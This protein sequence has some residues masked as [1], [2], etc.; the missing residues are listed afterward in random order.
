MPAGKKIEDERDAQ[1]CLTAAMRSGMTIRD[2]ARAQGID[3]RSLHAWAMNLGRRGTGAR[4]AGRAKA[5]R[6]ASARSLVELVPV[7]PRGGVVAS[8]ARGQA[9][10][11]LEVPGGRVEVGD[12]ASVA[13]LCRI[14]EA[15]R[16]C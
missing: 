15:L 10:Y 9:R 14:L 12:D 11:V 7:A 5:R 4:S 3:G 2:W 1:Q 13:T 16:Q 8:Q 6:V